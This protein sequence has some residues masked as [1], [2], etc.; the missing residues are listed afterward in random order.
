MF[1]S[2]VNNIKFSITSFFGGIFI[3]AGP[4]PFTIYYLLSL[5]GIT[6]MPT[7]IE[8]DALAERLAE[9]LTEN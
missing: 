5:L 9:A 1:N 2:D 8:I 3:G 6:Q 7:T 4:L